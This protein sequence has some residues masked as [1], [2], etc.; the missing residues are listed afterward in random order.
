MAN[1]LYDKARESFLKGDFNWSTNFLG[2]ALVDAAAYTPDFV[3]DD[4]LND[5][6]AA[7]PTGTAAIAI[8]A[9]SAT[10]RTTAAGVADA[11]DVTFPTVSAT[12]PSIEYVLLFTL[13]TTVISAITASACRLIGYIDSA[14]GL[15]ATPNGGDINVLWDN[16]GNRVFKL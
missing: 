14:T 13:N 1:R 6:D 2:V 10:S 5:V 16:G 9:M 15:P 7:A 3:N 8:V 11:A 12:A 4:F